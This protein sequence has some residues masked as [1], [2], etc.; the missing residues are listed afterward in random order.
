MGF[1]KVGGELQGDS[2]L[3]VSESVDC[4]CYNENMQPPSPAYD[5][6]YLAGIVYFNRQDYFEAHEVWE[7]LWTGCAGPERRFYQGLIQAAVGLHHFSAGNLRG[8]A[9]LYR[10]SRDYMAKFGSPFQ[11]LDVDD[12]WKAMERCC[13]G[14]LGDQPDASLRPDEALLPRIELNPPPSAW[15]VPKDDLDDEDAHGGEQQS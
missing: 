13:A 5:E 1:F 6:R 7:D 4:C 10:S 3:V 9:K 15:P 8:A 11:G 14:V 12:F 2:F